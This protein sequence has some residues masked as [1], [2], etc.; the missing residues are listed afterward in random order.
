MQTSFNSSKSIN[1]IIYVMQKNNF[2]NLKI[3]EFK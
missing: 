3:Y 1:Q 2:S